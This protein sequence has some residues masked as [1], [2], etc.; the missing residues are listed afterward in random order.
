MYTEQI[1]QRLGLAA[2]IHPQVVNNAT[3]STGGVDMSI[4]HRAFFP[5]DVGAITSNGSITATL[6]ESLDGSSNWTNLAGNNVSQSTITTASKLITFEV[7]AD[8]LTR[9]YVRLSVQETAG[10]NVNVCCIP[11]GD[12][13]NHKPGNSKNSTAVLAQNVVS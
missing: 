6:Q 13:A 8:Q 4:F 9:R 2:P 11:F 1:T 12:E 3:L 10:Q 7:R 5:L